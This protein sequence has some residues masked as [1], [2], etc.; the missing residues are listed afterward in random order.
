MVELLAPPG[1]RAPE[2]LTEGAL[3]R[4]VWA[5]PAVSFYGSPD[6][7]KGAEQSEVYEVRIFTRDPSRVSGQALRWT[8]PIM[9]RSCRYHRHRVTE[10]LS[11]AG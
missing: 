7:A 5:G 1:F 11:L 8:W 10:P 9:F 3:V 4:I 2:N 6:A